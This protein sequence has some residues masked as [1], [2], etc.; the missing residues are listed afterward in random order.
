MTKC[1]S[2]LLDG[3]SR[4]SD[5]VGLCSVFT[6]S[7]CLIQALSYVML[8][9]QLISSIVAE[10]AAVLIPSIVIT[11]GDAYKNR[12]FGRIT[13][14]LLSCKMVNWCFHIINWSSFIG[15]GSK[16]WNFTSWHVWIIYY[17]TLPNLVHV[18]DT[19]LEK[20]IVKYSSRTVKH[21]HIFVKHCVKLKLNPNAWF[22]IIPLDFN[23]NNYFNFLL[24]LTPGCNPCWA[25][26]KLSHDNW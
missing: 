23:S 11:V 15:N 13:L 22:D 18:L 21:V 16:I 20:S 25:I 24:I 1:L 10:T 9:L 5:Q 7:A 26:V 8:R 4:I 2:Y 14:T 19:L 6:I 12:L 17:S 3:V